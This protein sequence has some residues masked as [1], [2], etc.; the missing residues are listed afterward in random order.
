MIQAIRSYLK[1]SFEEFRRI[2]WPTKEQAV[3]LT[4]ATLVSSAVVA[5]LIALLDLGFSELYAK[6]ASLFQ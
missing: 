2:T 3:L 4:V 1:E 6:I 5:G